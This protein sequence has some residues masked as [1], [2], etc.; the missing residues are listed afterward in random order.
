[1]L[2]KVVI[3]I[4]EHAISNGRHILISNERP[5][6]LQVSEHLWATTC[7]DGEVE[8]SHLAV[9]FLHPSVE[10]SRP[11]SSTRDFRISTRIRAE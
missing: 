8:R 4:S 9:E 5:K 7:H 10:P 3:V 2:F 11:T 1:M 6:A